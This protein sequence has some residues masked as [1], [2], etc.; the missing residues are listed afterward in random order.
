MD[1]D[2]EL[3]ESGSLCFDFYC[4]LFDLSRPYSM[5]LYLEK[6]L[7]DFEESASDLR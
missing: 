2:S 1:W 7:F 4:D 6:V 5:L 3:C